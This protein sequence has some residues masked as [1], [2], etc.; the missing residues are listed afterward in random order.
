[1][2][3]Y[4]IYILLLLIAVNS[5][6]TDAKLSTQF[7][8][9]SGCNLTV[10]QNIGV[11]ILNVDVSPK[12]YPPAITV[13]YQIN[14]GAIVSEGVN[15]P[16][17]QGTTFNF[18][19]AQKANLSACDTDFNIV[20]WLEFVGDTDHSNDTLKWTVR[21]DCTVIPGQALSD[22]TVC[23]GIN[24][25]TVNLTG[26]SHGTVTSWIYSTNNGA[27]WS[28][29]SN[30][31]NPYNFSGLTTTTLYA[32]AINGGYCPNDTSTYTTITVDP[33]PIGGTLNGPTNLCIS[34]SSGTITLNGS[35]GAISNWE[36]ST[37]NGSTWSNIANTTTNESFTSLS[38]TTWYRVQ[39]DGGACPNVYSN[40]LQI[41]VDPLTVIG[42]LT[43]DTSVCANESVNLKLSSTIGD[44]TQW[45]SS[46]DGITW[47]PIASTNNPYNTGTLSSSIYYRVVA[48]SGICPSQTS[49]QIFVNV[50]TGVTPG[51]IAGADSLCESN[52]NGILTV[53]GNSENV[54]NWE[55]SVDNGTTWTTITNPTTTENYTGLTQTTWYR[56]LIDGNGC[57]NVYTDTAIIAVTSM[58]QAGTLTPDTSVCVGDAFNL[59]VN[60]SIGDTYT[61][62]VSPDGITW[63]DISNL[64]A[65]S[66]VISPVTSPNYYR[67]IVK[68]GICGTDVSNIVLVDTLGLP[69]VNAGPDVTIIK[70]DTT[71]LNGSGGLFGI[72][73]PGGTLSD[74]LIYM[75]N[76]FPV[77]TTTYILG[78]IGANGCFN[79]DEV[80]VI[81]RSMTFD[82]KNVITLND[83]SYN[84]TW[85]IEG[86]E[87]FPNTTVEVY[88]IYGQQVFKEDN[89][90]NDWKGTY[91]GKSLPNGTY[92]Y[93]AKPSGKD[94][95]AVKGTLTIMGHE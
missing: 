68:N 49:N 94:D 75:P 41:Q 64:V 12:I 51:N 65:P 56:A 59:K 7:S 40:V 20:V 50:T 73:T 15:T 91:K 28:S 17:D 76:A 32:V 95:G 61:W 1:M 47:T 60:G 93:I 55:S 6:A 11:V 18:T 16:I 89:Y 87:D 27:T 24:N 8:P 23:E 63:V 58:S 78:V 10:T 82:V 25:G 9:S 21:N 35:S 14:G 72:W 36:S 80:K 52:A 4:V 84:D 57:L 67:L 29:L 26:N 62:Q 45:E 46:S 5:H 71:Q 77:N 79:F 34:S 33:T 66:I 81:V 43:P 70:G 69:S 37:D 88:N 31:S 44:I 85:I 3:R 92:L 19:F 22:Q 53:S 48:Q 83:D 74:S 86:I 13:K 54:L 38:Q 90:K 42:T 30:T 39:I 2:V